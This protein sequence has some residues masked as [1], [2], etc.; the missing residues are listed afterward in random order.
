MYCEKKK[1]IDRIKSFVF[2]TNY[3]KRKKTVAYSM[4]QVNS[5]TV[6]T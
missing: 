1:N 4:F 3:K 6:L 5:V 2:W